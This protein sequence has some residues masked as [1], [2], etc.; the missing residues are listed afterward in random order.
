MAGGAGRIL[1]PVGPSDCLLGAPTVI[2]A[3]DPATVRPRLRGQ[4][5]GAG[6]RIKS[7]NDGKGWRLPRE[8]PSPIQKWLTEPGQNRQLPVFSEAGATLSS[9]A[10]VT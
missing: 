9:V 1:T 7:G 4:G 5:L 8:K 10:T 6:C 2:A 3:L